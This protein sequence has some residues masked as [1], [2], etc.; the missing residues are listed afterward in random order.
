VGGFLVPTRGRSVRMGSVVAHGILAVGLVAALGSCTMGP[1]PGA[2]T[3]THLVPATGLPANP[4]LPSS[5]PQDPKLAVA[6]GFLVVEESDPTVSAKP[7]WGVI[8][9]LAEVVSGGGRKQVGQPYEVAGKIYEPKVDTTYDSVGMASWYGGQFH[10]RTT[11]NG[12]IF[13][14]TAISAAHPTLPLPSYVRVTNMRNDRSIVVRV[15]DRGP[16]S[17]ERLIDVSE[18][19]AALLGFR[20]RGLTQVRVEYISSAPPEG[21]DKSVLLA[22][23]QGPPPAEPR[24]LLASSAPS[25]PAAPRPIAFASEPVPQ[26]AAA[27]MDNLTISMPT[28]DRILMAFEAA[29]D[30]EK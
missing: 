12:E 23:Y 9:R 6:N 30:A 8:R 17:S 11:A 4:K 19:T 29:G 26:P 1:S 5:P 2:V 24:L 28:A 7:D 22:T 3:T 25:G 10:G 21:E 14:R 27:A 18:Q 16:Y 15:N 20:K 13:D